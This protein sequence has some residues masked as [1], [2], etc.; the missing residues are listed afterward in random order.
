MHNLIR[1]FLLA[2]LAVF[3][4]GTASS[5]AE[6]AGAAFPDTMNAGGNTLKLNGLGLRK[7]F[8][9]KVYVGGLYLESLSTDADKILATDQARAVRMV[10]LRDLTRAQLVEGFQNGFAANAKDRAGQQAAFDRMLALIHDVKEGETLTLAY[11]P[12][13]GTRLQEGER[14]LGT[15][16]GSGFARDLFS[17]WLGPQPPT[18]DLKA[19]MLTGRP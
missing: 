8:M 13:K 6:L 15:F 18:G 7:K 1:N 14:T 5:A 19:G 17:I 3:V 10:F 9:F 12:G 2:F 4:F 11:L 16:E